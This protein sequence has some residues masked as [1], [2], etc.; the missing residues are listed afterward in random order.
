MK[1]RATNWRSWHVRCAVGSVGVAIA[2]GLAA[3]SGPF[4]TPARLPALYVGAVEVQGNGGYVLVSVVDMPAGG[5]AAIQLGE[6]GNK[7][8]AYGDI[9]PASVAVEG[10]NG[11]VVLAEAFDAAG[12]AVIAASGVDG[13]MDGGI[14]RFTFTVTGDDP[15][16]AVA[17]TLVKIASDDGEFVEAWTLKTAA[18]AAY[19]ARSETDW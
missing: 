13:V 16:F 1:E 14:L 4:G 19:V 5:I 15:T 2:A 9:D 7:A 12:G 17:K 10:K 3:C 8:I 18:D 6:V 11:F